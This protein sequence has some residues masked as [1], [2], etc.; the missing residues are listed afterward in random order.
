MIEAVLII[1][2]SLTGTFIA[3]VFHDPSIITKVSGKAHDFS[4]GM[5]ANN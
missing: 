4:R 2:G 5:K 3:M 1:I